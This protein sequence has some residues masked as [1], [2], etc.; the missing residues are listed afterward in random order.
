MAF[1]VVGPTRRRKDSVRISGH[2]VAEA[3]SGAGSLVPQG[4]R[5]TGSSLPQCPVW[6]RD[7]AGHH[8]ERAEKEAPQQGGAAQERSFS[9]LASAELHSI[10]VQTCL[11]LCVFLLSFFVSIN[12]TSKWVLGKVPGNRCQERQEW[13]VSQPSDYVGMN[14]CFPVFKGT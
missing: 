13:F 10:S 7:C 1:S 9:I 8:S 11:S 2:C 3:P 4:G 6:T 5:N 12:C 14:K